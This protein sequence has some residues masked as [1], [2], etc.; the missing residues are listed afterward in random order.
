MSQFDAESFLNVSVEGELETRIEP[1]PPGEYR[2]MIEKIEARQQGEYS[3]MEVFWKIE[4]PELAA[5]LGREKLT[6]RQSIF[7]DISEMG[8]ID[9]AKGK[10][11]Q[12]G[13]LRAAV[14]QNGP[15][16]WSP[17][18]L[19]AQMAVVQVAQR[20]KDEEVYDYVKSVAH[21]DTFDEDDE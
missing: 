3:I 12:L 15:E 2:A 10:N 4:D 17:R 1:I 14:D 20:K 19:M 13:R 8:T 21:I 9:L 5:E 6:C 11:V 18:D 7:L 16:A